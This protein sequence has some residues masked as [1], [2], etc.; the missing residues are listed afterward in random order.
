MSAMSA[1]PS[2]HRVVHLIRMRT[3]GGGVLAPL[4]IAAAERVHGRIVE[5]EAL[6]DEDFAA[7]SAMARRTGVDVRRTGLVRLAMRFAAFR[8]M[9][10]PDVVHLHSGMDTLSGNLRPIRAA[11]PKS[12]PLIVWLH[13]S[14]ELGDADDGRRREHVRRSLGVDAVVVPSA[15]QLEAQVAAGV[16][17]E[18]LHIVPAIVPRPVTSLGTA[19]ARLGISEHAR[20][21]LF[22]GRMIDSKNPLLTVAAFRASRDRDAVLVM[23][24]DGPLIG[25]VRAAAADLGERVRVLGHVA[26]VETLYADADL[27]VSPST[28]ESFG[29]TAFEALQSGTACALA[30]IRPW[31][32]SL[33]DGVD[34]DF[35]AVNATPDEIAKVM[36]RLL[37]DRHQRDARAAAGNARVQS[38]F[39]TSAALAALDKVYAAGLHRDKLRLER[40]GEVDNATC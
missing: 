6:I 18:K 28:T 36:D 9:R 34:V 24:G 17:P 33:R 11:L 38:L 37:L 40:N 26:D 32:D 20:V 2:P 35:F 15:S 5:V 19:R 13:G 1:A 16:D 8:L 21:V 3:A 23:A 27:F 7:V 4:R 25:D 22:C 12:V 30:S 29:L 39:S 10:R 14:G 31:T